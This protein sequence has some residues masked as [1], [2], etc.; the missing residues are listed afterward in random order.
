M[1]VR[2][3]KP[4][5]LAKAA[6]RDRFGDSLIDAWWRGVDGAKDI[7]RLSALGGDTNRRLAQA[8]GKKPLN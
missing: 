1:A 4:D 7:D 2:T 6:G 5:W 3:T 8:A